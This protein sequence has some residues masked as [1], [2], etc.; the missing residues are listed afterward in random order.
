MPTSYPMR[1]VRPHSGKLASKNGKLLRG[2]EFWDPVNEVFLSPV[3]PRVTF[4]GVDAGACAD[5]TVAL[6][7]TYDLDTVT[8]AFQ[9]LD[10]NTLTSFDAVL[11]AASNASYW[12]G[13]ETVNYYLDIYFSYWSPCEELMG[14]GNNIRVTTIRRLT[15][16]P[17]GTNDG[18]GAFKHNGYKPLLSSILCC[19]GFVDSFTNENVSPCTFNKP[20]IT[21][22]ATLEMVAFP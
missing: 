11:Y 13:S 16:S 18:V 7:G 10:A 6:D 21:G 3:M 20:S 8:G 17:E 22:T 12:D 19:S 9:A 1:I 2:C 15:T 4:T 14:E 5:W